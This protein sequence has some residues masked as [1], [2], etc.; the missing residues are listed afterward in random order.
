MYT[1]AEKIYLS[2]LSPT[3]FHKRV[4]IPCPQIQI[5]FFL[6][7]SIS[8][9]FFFLSFCLSSALAQFDEVQ[10][11]KIFD[12]SNQE[13]KIICLFVYLIGALSLLPGFVVMGWICAALERHSRYVYGIE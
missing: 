5:Q 13:A 7:V 12:L 2:A 3:E 10:H 1:G 11:D 4:R 6:C 9:Q 8:K